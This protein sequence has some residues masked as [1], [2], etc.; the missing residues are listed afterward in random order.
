M[1]I[2]LLS[3]LFV[4]L[5]TSAY[6]QS[7]ISMRL[8]DVC[9]ILAGRPVQHDTIFTQ[10]F[11]DQVSPAKLSTIVQQVTSEAGPCLGIRVIDQ[12]SNYSV[13]AEATTALGWI[14]PI[15]LTVEP[16]APYKIAG[17]FIRPPVKPVANLKGIEEEFASLSG[18]SSL[19][20][21]DLTN[22]TVLASH[23]SSTRLPIGSTFKLYVLGELAR[24]I[25]EGTLKWDDVILLDSSARSMPSGV[26]QSWPHGSPLTVHTLACEMIS[27]S[28]N[29]ATDHLLRF[30]GAEAVYRQQ[31]FMGHDAPSVND[32]FL[33]TRQLCMLKYINNGV[34]AKAYAS[35]SASERASI[36]K[37]IATQHSFAEVNYS[38]KPV[39]QDSVEWFATTQ[40]LTR[41]MNWLRQKASGPAGEHILN[42]MSINPGLQIDSKSWKR[43]CYKGGSEPGVINMT[44]LLQHTNGTWYALSGTWLSTHQVDDVKFAGLIERAIRLLAP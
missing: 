7:Q 39:Y 9:T 21:V 29:T 30:L 38:D 32:P 19:T 25:N 12:R 10:R 3:C 33:S 37:D 14:I 20:V 22:G 35:A 41:A 18:M 16:S 15:T 11:L 26:L 2:V 36:L 5:A 27:I 44:Y 4:L 6:A 13:T 1:R 34:A 24:R 23:A 42:V 28:D 17:F 40:E 43:I 8:Q 31:E